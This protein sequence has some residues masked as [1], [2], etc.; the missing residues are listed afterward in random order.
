MY[1]NL[2][3]YTSHPLIITNQYP[4][5][6]YISHDFITRIEYYI[7]IYI[8]IYIHNII[9][10][11]WYMIYNTMIYDLYYI[12]I[13]TKI[14]VVISHS[15]YGLPRS[16]CARWGALKWS[17]EKRCWICAAKASSNGPGHVKMPTKKL[18]KCGEHGIFMVISWDFMAI[19]GLV[20][21]HHGSWHWKNMAFPMAIDFKWTWWTFNT[22]VPTMRTS[23]ST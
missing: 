9:Q 11:I 2:L 20:G 5:Y 3:G 17:A 14:P 23:R 4:I 12:Y 1:Y 19:F 15:K 8:I 21:E 16:A 18:G 7:Y 13:Y 6:I 22:W 10:F